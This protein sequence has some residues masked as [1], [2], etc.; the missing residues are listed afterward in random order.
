VSRKYVALVA[1]GTTAL[2]CSLIGPAFVLNSSQYQALAA[3]VQAFGVVAALV[4]AA[5]TFAR[6]AQD[7]RVDRVSDLDQAYQSGTNFDARRR[8]RE[9]IGASDGTAVP[10][11]QVQLQSDASMGTYARGS[12]R[13]RTSKRCSDTLSP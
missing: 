5:V 2:L 1:S 4:S 3:G 6:E 10:V 9:H 7:R 11:T 8:M 13:R 12:V